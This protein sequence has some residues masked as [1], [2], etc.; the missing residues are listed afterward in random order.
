MRRFK[1]LGPVCLPGLSRASA[2]GGGGGLA[3]PGCG[4]LAGAEKLP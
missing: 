1:V 4:S 2:Q 3:D